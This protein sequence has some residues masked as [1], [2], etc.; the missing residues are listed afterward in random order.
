MAGEIDV[1]RLEA[2]K[3]GV[4]VEG[5]RYGPI[6]VEIDRIGGLNGWL[7]VSLTEGKN[8][9]IRKVL[10]HLGLS[11]NRLQRVSYGPFDLDKL[12]VGDFMPIGQIHV[13]ALLKGQEVFLD[14]P[15]PKAPKKPRPA[16]PAEKPAGP[17]GRARTRGEEPVA[18]SKAGGRETAYKM[19][20][21]DRPKAPRG[22]RAEPAAR[23]APA[24]K[25][26]AAAKPPAPPPPPP[27]KGR[28]E[29]RFSSR[30]SKAP[31]PAPKSPPAPKG[32]GNA[33]RR[34][35]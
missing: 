4:T 8:R 22:T 28:S 6:D 35:P 34:R 7:Y 31:A 16:A 33:H 25:R 14:K 3:K 21:P 23:P 19:G 20:P 24:P 18:F 13:D 15:E 30:P 26:E 5:V 2:L 29:V 27:P 11:V 12:G 9:E 17:R 10:E 1:N 32:P